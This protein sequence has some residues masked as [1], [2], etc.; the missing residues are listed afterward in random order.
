MAAIAQSPRLTRVITTVERRVV[1]P[2]VERILRSRLHPLLSRWL[3][4]LGYEGRVSGT[5]I[6]TPV[7]Y[8]WDGPNIVVLTVRDE[9][10]WWKNFRDEYPATLRVRGTQLQTSGRAVTDISVIADWLGELD[11]R[12]RIWNILLREYGFTSEW[13]RAERERAAAELVVVRFVPLTHQRSTD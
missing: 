8:E 2:A 11:G 4:L 6:A 3:A 10:T 1:N 5:A 9:T 7:L 13:T 12:S